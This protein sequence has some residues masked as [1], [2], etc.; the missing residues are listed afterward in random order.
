MRAV[1]RLRRG[2]TVRHAEVLLVEETHGA[3]VQHAAVLLAVETHGATVRHAAA[4]LAVETHGATVLHGVAPPG[5]AAVHAVATHDVRGQ[6]HGAGKGVR[7]KAPVCVAA[8][9][10]P[11]QHHA[12]R[13]IFASWHPRRSPA[14]LNYTR[15]GAL[16]Q[17]I[18]VRRQLLN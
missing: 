15:G 9:S 11:G 8:A 3:T 6:A 17:G 12:A 7:V 2:A 5:A 18:G 1:A 4:L 14:Q 16:R 10:C 13:G